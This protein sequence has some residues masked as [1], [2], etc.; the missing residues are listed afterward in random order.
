[1][2]VLRRLEG[3]DVPWLFERAGAVVDAVDPVSAH[4]QRSA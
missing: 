1:L 2:F 3:L 4:E